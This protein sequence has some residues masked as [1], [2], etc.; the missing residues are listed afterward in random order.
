MTAPLATTVRAPIVTSSPIVAFAAI[1]ADASMRARGEM[2]GGCAG[3]ALSGRSRSTRSMNAARGSATAM[4]AAPSRGRTAN[5]DDT[6]ITLA[7]VVSS[8]SLRASSQNASA[9]GVASDSEATPLAITSA[10]P[11]SVAPGSMAA[12]SRAAN[13]RDNARANGRFTPL[14]APSPSLLAG[15]RRRRRRRAPLERDAALPHVVARNVGRRHEAREIDARAFHPPQLVEVLLREADPV[16]HGRRV[17]GAPRPVAQLLEHL[18][19]GAG[20][21]GIA[22]HRPLGKHVVAGE[23]VEHVAVGVD[24]AAVRAGVD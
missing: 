4:S 2:P 21:A 18:P 1:D 24:E 14:T 10:A 20:S 23:L 9:P 11:T 17:V 22:R 12:S 13:G 5:V 7:A 8:A 16:V 6:T 19:V 3:R 15:H